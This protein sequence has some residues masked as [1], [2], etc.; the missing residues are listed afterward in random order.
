MNRL[1]ASQ[2]SSRTMHDGLDVLAVA[3]PQGGDQFRVLLAPLGVEPLLELV[4]DQQ[5][6][7]ARREH[8]TSPHGRERIDQTQSRRAGRGMP[9]AA[10]RSSRVSVS[11]AVAST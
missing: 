9:S 11:S 1:T 2:K 4:E 8:A 7:L 10:V 3:L 6:L 5:H